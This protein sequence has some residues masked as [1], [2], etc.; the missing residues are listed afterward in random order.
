MYEYPTPFDLL[1]YGVAQLHI[2]A[3][4]KHNFAHVKCEVAHVKCEIAQ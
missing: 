1:N 3:H 4:V 2:F